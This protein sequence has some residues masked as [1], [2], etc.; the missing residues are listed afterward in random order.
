MCNDPHDDQTAEMRK[1]F[2]Q[3]VGKTP[4][5][6]GS[7]STRAVGLVLVV[8]GLVVSCLIVYFW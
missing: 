3:E 4:E 7:D 5:Q 8:L 2:Y 1:K 6:E